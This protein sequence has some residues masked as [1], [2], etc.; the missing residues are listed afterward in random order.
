MLLPWLAISTF[1]AIIP[2]QV[3]G[4]LRVTQVR[5]MD[6]GSGEVRTA[7]ESAI[8]CVYSCEVSSEDERNTHCAARIRLHQPLHHAM[9]CIWICCYRGYMLELTPK[10]WE[11][12]EMR[13]EFGSMHRNFFRYHFVVTNIQ[14]NASMTKKPSL[15]LV[16]EWCV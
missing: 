11:E 6:I 10:D 4:P 12:D 14:S 7:D 13:L 5:R 1:N 8:L 3:Y 15:N 16:N 9:L 2:W